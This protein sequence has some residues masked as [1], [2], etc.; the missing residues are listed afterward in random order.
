[1]T[2]T[3]HALANLLN[4]WRTIRRLEAENQRLKLSLAKSTL[5]IRQLKEE[6]AL[7][8]QI[9]LKSRR[10]IACQYEKL[11]IAGEGFWRLRKHGWDGVVAQPVYDWIRNDMTG[12]LPP[13]PKYLTQRKGQADAEQGL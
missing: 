10:L 5:Q 6:L 13:L 11:V 7:R 2:P 1:M 8:S 12:P 9:N 3:L 4:P